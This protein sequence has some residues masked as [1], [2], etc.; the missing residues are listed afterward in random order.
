VLE[1]GKTHTGRGG[2]VQA[3]SNVVF[4]KSITGPIDRLKNIFIIR[5][6]KFDARRVICNSLPVA[7]N[8][9]RTKRTND[10]ETLKNAYLL[11]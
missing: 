9:D 7:T 1:A 10:H 5:Q 11:R 2:G 8:G 6:N 4:N 3:F